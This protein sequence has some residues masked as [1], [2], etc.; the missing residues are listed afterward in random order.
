MAATYRKLPGD[1]RHGRHVGL[2]GGGPKVRARAA[3]RVGCVGRLGH[4]VGVGLPGVR[5]WIFG[6]GW[7]WA[8]RWRDIQRPDFG[9]GAAIFHHEETKGTKGLWV[10]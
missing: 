7:R 6:G 5:R 9:F 1:D 8:R 2:A 10:R 3:G 4:P